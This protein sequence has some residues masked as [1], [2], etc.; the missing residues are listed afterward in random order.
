MLNYSLYQTYSPTFNNEIN[1]YKIF[2]SGQ[3][4]ISGIKPHSNDRAIANTMGQSLY[5]TT[6]TSLSRI[7]NSNIQVSRLLCSTVPR[8]LCLL[9]FMSIRTAKYIFIIPRFS[10][11]QSIKQSSLI[12]SE[13]KCFLVLIVILV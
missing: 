9:I 3:Y 10:L 12:K 5:A 1:P 4:A 13:Q 7:T 8:D 2:S 6:S 11:K